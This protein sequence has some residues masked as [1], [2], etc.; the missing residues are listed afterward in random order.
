MTASNGS[1][2]E[3]DANTISQ[4]SNN[5]KSN[6]ISQPLTIT[7]DDSNDYSNRGESAQFRQTFGM[8][9]IGKGGNV[10]SITSSKENE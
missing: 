5:T 4:K 9:T 7:Y 10:C 6:T 8:K 3:S 2:R 1:A